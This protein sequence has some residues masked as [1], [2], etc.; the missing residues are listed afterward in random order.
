[1]KKIPLVFSLL[2]VLGSASASAWTTG[3]REFVFMDSRVT[4]DRTAL[5]TYVTQPNTVATVLIKRCYP[6]GC[7]PVSSFQVKNTK[8]KSV[9]FYPNNLAQR[10]E[11]WGRVDKG[12]GKLSLKVKLK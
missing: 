1:M 11:Y 7:T 10:Y 2:G 6:S 3:S 8:P 9:Q 12:P 4:G 5:V